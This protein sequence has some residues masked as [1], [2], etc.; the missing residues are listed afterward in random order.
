MPSTQEYSIGDAWSNWHVSIDG[1]RMT[2][3]ATHIGE[4]RDSSDLYDA[5]IENMLANDADLDENGSLDI[6]SGDVGAEDDSSRSTTEI[7][8]IK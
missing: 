4:V 1:P 7:S 5:P 3:S 2:Q 8:V 6:S